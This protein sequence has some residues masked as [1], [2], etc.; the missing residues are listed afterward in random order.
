MGGGAFAGFSGTGDTGVEAGALE[1]LILAFSSTELEEK[2]IIDLG[3]N[4]VYMGL[5][6]RKPVHSCLL[7]WQ[8]TR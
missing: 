8:I 5:D 3:V 7:N 4:P 1:L 6:A 2:A